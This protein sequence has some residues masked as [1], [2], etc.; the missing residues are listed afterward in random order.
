MRRIFSIVS[1]FFV[2][3]AAARAQQRP[4]FD[5]DDFVDPRQQGGAIFISRLVAGAGTDLTDDYRPLRNDGGFLLLTNSFYWHQIQLDYKH[6][7]ISNNDDKVELM[8]CGCQQRIFF[9]TPPSATATPLAPPQTAKE[10]LQFGLYYSVP[11][12][13]TEPP[14][15]LRARLTGNRRS[16]NTVVRS[17]PALEVTEHRSGHE[18]S[19]GVDADTYFRLGPHDV[20]GEVFYARTTQSGTTADRSQSEFA[21]MS[22]F[23][24]W[25]VGPLLVRATLTA[26]SISGRGAHGINLLNPAFEA[27]WH[28]P[29]S[30]ANLHL[31]WS[32]QSTRSGN[33]G[34]ETHQ[35]IALF[36]DRALYVKLFGSTPDP[37]TAR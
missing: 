34:W 26:G 4:I 28:L 21:Y 13:G 18:Q 5:P 7:K 19:F 1:F 10:T 25:A 11:G 2:V 37:N 32:P 12:R 17:F 27:F 14:V 31:V 3:A 20:W 36:V 15:M 29:A 8:T 35:Q 9:P 33:G 6:S 24:A 30:G 23:P 16:F 22:R